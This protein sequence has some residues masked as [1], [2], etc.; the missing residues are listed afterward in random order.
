LLNADE[1]GGHQCN[2]KEGWRICREGKLVQ[3]VGE[4]VGCI[5]MSV[6]IALARRSHHGRTAQHSAAQRTFV[7]R[8]QQQ[9]RN[10]SSFC[11]SNCKFGSWESI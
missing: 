9:Q 1:L 10:S 4:R 5:R 2:Q 6:G 11:A 7:H 3:H 8:T